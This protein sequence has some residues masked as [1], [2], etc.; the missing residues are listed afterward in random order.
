MQQSIHRVPSQIV[1][2][3]LLALFVTLGTGQERDLRGSAERAGTR[4]L[5]TS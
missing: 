5:R 2:G 3:G 4:T 1:T